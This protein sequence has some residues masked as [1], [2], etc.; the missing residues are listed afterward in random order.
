MAEELAAIL[1]AAARHDASDV[2]WSA[3]LPVSYRVCGRWL[4]TQTEPLT[5]AEVQ[6]LLEALL[7][8]ER[9]EELRARRE[10]TCMAEPPGREYRYRCQLFYQ[11]GEPA[12]VLRPVP[13][14][15]P[16]LREL[17]LP[18]ELE[19]L[20]IERGGGL[21]LLVGPHGHGTTT[22]AAALVDAANRR[23]RCHIVKV[24]AP[25]EFVHRSEL[26]LIEHREVGRDTPDFEQA[27]AQ[28]GRLAP[29]LVVLGALPERATL[30]RALA[31]A[32]SGTLV[33]AT[34]PG[35]GVVPALEG[36][37]ESVVLF[38]QGRVRA[39][40]ARVVRA[41]LAQRLLR[42]RE[43]KAMVPALEL[44]HATAEV[45]A[46]I[47]EQR[48]PQLRREME[49]GVLGMVTLEQSAAR[50]VKEGLVSQAEAAPWLAPAPPA[51]PPAPRP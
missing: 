11:A 22:T 1:D 16:R 25:V 37:V 19:E 38:E 46:L 15:I 6:R 36:I 39:Q 4:P 41:V 35:S 44:L 29:D 13:Y 28:I 5:G 9:L 18:E 24:E 10:L 14:R 43:G 42:T 33:L 3:G 26:A 21:V 17:G 7:P 12:A 20:V 31:L 40:L 45:R 51:A 23:R 47:E 8:G 49:S 2:L 50:L 34:L 27:L 30:E 32:A 48:L